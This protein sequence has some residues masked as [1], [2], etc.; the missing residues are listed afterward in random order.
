[1][2]TT[3]LTKKEQEVH[4]LL[5][6]TNGQVFGCRFRR[7]DGAIRDFNG[8]YQPSADDPPNWNPLDKGMMIVYDFQK[9]GYRT[10]TLRTVSEIRFGG[11][12]HSF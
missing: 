7:K 8:Q 4:N 3:T 1:M 11:Q 12:T 9:Q 5:I 6:S 10:I 2:A